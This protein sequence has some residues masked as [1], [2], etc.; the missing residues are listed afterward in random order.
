MTDAAAKARSAEEKLCRVELLEHALEARAA[1]QRAAL[2]QADMDR[3]AVLQARCATAITEREALQNRRAAITVPAADVL[4]PMRRLANDL[5]GARGALN[6]GLIVTVT[7]SRPIDIRVK[8][9]GTDVDPTLTG[10]AL[11]LEANAELDIDIDDIATVRV[12]G[13]RREA[14]QTVR[15]AGGLVGAA[16]SRRTLWLPTS[17]TSRA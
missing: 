8:K 11:E 15:I 17:R 16:K 1:D 6:V 13:G 2:A 9:D 3:H 7:P 14:Q 4:G 12:R 10:K 5:A